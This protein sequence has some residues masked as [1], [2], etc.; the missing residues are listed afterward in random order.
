MLGSERF[1]NIRPPDSQTDLAAAIAKKQR[2]SFL[3]YV[4]EAALLLGAR[5]VLLTDWLTDASDGIRR[6][7]L[8]H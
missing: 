5:E 1:L 6:P 8:T 3:L 4:T 2:L 7:T